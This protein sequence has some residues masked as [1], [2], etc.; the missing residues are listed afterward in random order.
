VPNATQTAHSLAGILL[1]ASVYSGLAFFAT[2][3]CLIFYPITRAKNQAIADELAE[4]RLKFAPR[5]TPE[6]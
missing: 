5:E 3:V 4:R 1:V 6:A 2:A